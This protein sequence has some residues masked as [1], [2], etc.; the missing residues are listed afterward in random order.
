MQRFSQLAILEPHPA[1]KSFLQNS[2][3]NCE[4][5][6]FLVLILPCIQLQLAM[7]NKLLCMLCNKL[8]C[9][10]P[11]VTC[12]IVSIKFI[13]FTEPAVVCPLLT[14]PNNGVMICSLEDDG[15]PSFEDTCSFTCNTGHELTG[16]DTRT[17]RSDGSWSGSETTCSGGG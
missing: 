1:F 14:D 3:P 11:F 6:S 9:N 12:N 16:S 13:H 2:L 10:G 8:S 4:K 7:F 5:T 17:C 15:V